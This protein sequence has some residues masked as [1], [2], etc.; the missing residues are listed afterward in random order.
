MLRP[1]S[2]PT[3]SPQRKSRAPLASIAGDHRTE[4]EFVVQTGADDIVAQAAG[5]A[6]CEG[7]AARLES[8]HV[9]GA[10]EVDVQVFK[11]GG[12][13]TRDVRLDATARGP[14]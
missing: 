11:F 2:G 8:K 10:A 12:P 4:T 6:K 13:V 7:K 5:R 14:A 3:A 1:R 9:G